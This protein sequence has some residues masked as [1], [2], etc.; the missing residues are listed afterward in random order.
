M[1]THKNTDT[2]NNIETILYKDSMTKIVYDNGISQIQELYYKGEY[3]EVNHYRND[4]WVGRKIDNEYIGDV[5][6]I[7]AYENGSLER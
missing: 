1:N 2:Q 6:Y 7:K 3:I 5:M 4:E